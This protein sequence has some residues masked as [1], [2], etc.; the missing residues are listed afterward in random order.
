ML[1][2][3]EEVLLSWRKLRIVFF[4]QKK[5]FF[6]KKTKISPKPG[7]VNRPSL[8]DN[9]GCPLLVDSL[10]HLDGDLLLNLSREIDFHRMWIHI[11]IYIDSHH[12]E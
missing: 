7:R 9:D 2:K 12:V 10:A 3:I 11:W 8:A 6:L 1:Y 4:K 5:F